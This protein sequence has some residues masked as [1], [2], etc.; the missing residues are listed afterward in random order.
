MLGF[1]QHLNFRHPNIL[2]LFGYFYDDH[3]I[4]LI[5][6][7]APRGEM[8]KVLQKCQGGKFDEPKAS[9]YIKQMTQVIS[10]HFPASEQLDL[11]QTC[12]EKSVR[13]AFK[14]KKNKK[15]GFFPHWGGGGSPPNPH[16]F[17]S[18]DFQGGVGGLGSNFHTFLSNF[19]FFKN[20]VLFYPVFVG[21]KVIFRVKLKKKFFSPK[22]VSTL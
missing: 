7:F 10:L 3:K 13:E 17:K 15:C 5:L 18:V 20:F 16:F 1:N 21:C 12:I 14:K 19:I 22:C 11:P 4:Y 2:R 8:Y 9:K 6:E